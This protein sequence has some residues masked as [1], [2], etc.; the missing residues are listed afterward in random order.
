ME[1]SEYKWLTLTE[2]GLY[3]KMSPSTLYKWAQGGKLPGVKVGNQWRFDRDTIDAWILEQSKGG[4]A[5][6]RS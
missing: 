1:T 5:G 6:W 2:L 4:D 3:I